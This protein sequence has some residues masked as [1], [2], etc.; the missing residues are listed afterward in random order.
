MATAN[1]I[2]K[3]FSLFIDGKGYAGNIDELTLPPLTTKME[4]FRA[5]GMDSSIAIEMGQEKMEFKFTLS[6]YEPAALA[7]WGVGEGSS[8][9][10]VARGAVQNLD[11][12]VEP[13]IVTMR[14]TIRSIEPAAWQA[15]NKSSVPF[16]VDLRAYKYEQNGV[17]IHDID[18][19][20]MIRL[21]NGVDALQSQ[22]D[23]IGT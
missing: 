4:D 17:V 13:V 5:G 22:R 19:V 11:G 1:R 21:V 7:L 6:A 14:G 10:L 18:V 3:N 15:G 20:N 8:V 2:L 9:P 12:T 16:T 23:A